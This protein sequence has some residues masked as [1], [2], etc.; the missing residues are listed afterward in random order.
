VKWLALGACL[1]I[2]CPTADTLRRN[3]TYRQIA[4]MLV[5]F[6]PFVTQ[7]G[8]LFM[9]ADPTTWG[10][11]V[12]GFEISVLDLIALALFLILP[13]PRQRIPFK[14]VMALYFSTVVVSAF[15]A[16][17]P[18]ESLFYAWQLARMFLVY[19]TIVKGCS[20]NRTTGAVLTGMAGG[21]IVEA[22]FAAWERFGLGFIQTGGTVGAQNLL[23]FM[24]HFVIL[25]VFALLLAGQ[26]GWLLILTLLAGF[27]V[28]ISTASRATIGL[29][30]GALVLVFLLSSLRQW[31]PW[32]GRILAASVVGV[33][34]LVPL[35]IHSFQ[36]RFAVDPLTGTYD[37][38]AAYVKAA[39][40]ML[41]DH[42]LGIG[43]NQFA[44]VG[45]VDHYYERAGVQ[46]WSMSLAGNV[47]N[48]YYLT[49]AETGYPGLLALLLL[50]I[51]PLV[52]AFRCGWRNSRNAKDYRGHLLLGLAVTLS[53]VY[54][55]SWFEWSMA[56]YAAQY[57]IAIAM[58]LVAG[59]AQQLGY[60]TLTKAAIAQTT[61]G[62]PK[63]VIDPGR[64]I[65]DQAGQ[66]RHL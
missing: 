57:L 14:F 2:L 28:V 22:V 19:A 33:A 53:A 51:S 12:K 9:D 62:L 39:Q 34:L 59:N 17:Q 15:Q 6:L 52:V 24:S 46:I 60:W 23:G 66:L 54:I 65:S 16:S 48:F 43:A 8:H 20:D 63:L 25:P 42:P 4:W 56:T 10:G 41:A 32:K 26:R 7:Y 1:A 18:K 49:A 38:R 58:G 3:A 35:V 64:Q 55:H 31:T 50:L 36:D 13:R 27:L 37:E 30:A 11:Y 44:V 5:G 29:E 47:H 61:S 40:L 45:N 21:L